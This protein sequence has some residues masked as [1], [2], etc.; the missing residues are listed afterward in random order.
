MNGAFIKSKLVK[1]INKAGYDLTKINGND[2]SIPLIKKDILNLDKIYFLAE[3]NQLPF[4]CFVP[5]AYVRGHVMNFSFTNMSH[6]FKKAV[7]KALKKEH[8]KKHIKKELQKFYEEVKPDN[9]AEV[10]GLTKEEAPN[11]AQKEPWVAVHPWEDRTIAEV[12]KNRPIQ[13]AKENKKNGLDVGIEE[14]WHLFGPVSESKLE[15]EAERILELLKKFESTEYKPYQNKNNI[16][17][18]IL[19]D[20]KADKLKWM[21]Y[22]GQ[23]R[24]SILSA[25]DYDFIPVMVTK[26]VSRKNVDFWP[27]VTAGDFTKEAALKVFDA[28]INEEQSPSI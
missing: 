24:T 7:K 17:A 20:K 11:L 16:T 19:I 9:A 8:R 14:G 1:L 26:I 22:D 28:I 2:D 15:V 18:T 3:S 23:H 4:I 10:L 12:E 6:P 5:V 25:L 21:I 13:T 27:G